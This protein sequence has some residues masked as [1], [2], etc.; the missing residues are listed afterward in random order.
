MSVCVRGCVCGWVG[1]RARA[2]L[3]ACV[4]LCVRACAYVCVSAVSASAGGAPSRIAVIMDIHSVFTYRV[5]MHQR[6]HV[7][8][9]QT[10][11]GRV[12]LTS[13]TLP[14]SAAL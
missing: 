12:A 14:C 6:C 2:R 7:P 1:A 8:R 4:C 11:F 3:C 13:L 9:C 5:S 10:K